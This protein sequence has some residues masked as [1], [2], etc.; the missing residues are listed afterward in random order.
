MRKSFWNSSSP[1]LSECSHQGSRRCCEHPPTSCHHQSPLRVT[2]T[3]DMRD[4][5][6]KSNKIIQMCSPDA[7][8]VQGWGKARPGSSGFPNTEHSESPS[9]TSAWLSK[10]IMNHQHPEC[11]LE[12]NEPSSTLYLLGATSQV[13]LFP[14]HCQARAPRMELS[15][16]SKMSKGNKSSTEVESFKELNLS[17]TIIN[18]YIPGMTNTQQQVHGFGCFSSCRYHTTMGISS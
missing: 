17:Y 15:T 11:L 1:P 10:L 9:H 16:E 6:G 5:E 3:T 2:G 13:L 4:F 7:L 8:C 12:E 18:L 14:A